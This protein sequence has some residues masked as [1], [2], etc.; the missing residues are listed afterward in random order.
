VLGAL[1]VEPDPGQGAAQL[2]AQRDAE[3]DGLPP[4]AAERAEGDSGGEAAQQT[5][6]PGGGAGEE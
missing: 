3:V 5:A 4:G 2:T 1:D 6:D